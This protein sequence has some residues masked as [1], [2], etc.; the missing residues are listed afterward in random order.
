[1]TARRTATVLITACLAVAVATTPAGAKPAE[2]PPAQDPA[3]APTAATAA[4]A[5]AHS[6]AKDRF[7]ARH[8]LRRAVT[9]ENFYFV[10]ADRFENGT[11]ANDTGGISGGKMEHGFDPTHKG[12]DNGGDLSGLLDRID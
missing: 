6:G 12:F 7:R 1:M 8:S 9:D 10:M 2:P 11:T 3:A 4:T 5:A